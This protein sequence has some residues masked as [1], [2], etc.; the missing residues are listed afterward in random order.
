MNNPQPQKKMSA[1]YAATD[2]RVDV[3]DSK[4][5][6]SKEPPCFD[7]PTLADRLEAAH[8]SWKYYA[9]PRG[10]VGYIWS[11]L[12]AIKHIRN[13]PLWTSKVVP[14]AQ[15]AE[16]ARNGRL[17]AGRW[18]VAGGEREDPTFRSW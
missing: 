11:A 18:L 8:V 3:M 14:D 12:D 17:P 1:C 4:G 16:D 5:E 7:L 2:E 9:P 15:F 10:Q 6:I 13:G